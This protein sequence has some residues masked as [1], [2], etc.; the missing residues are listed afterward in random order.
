MPI[1]PQDR[2]RQAIDRLRND[3]SWFIQSRDETKI[4][5]A[6]GVAIRGQLSTAIRLRG[7]A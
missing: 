5:V 4:N 7:H 3:A 1:T 2:A 6:W